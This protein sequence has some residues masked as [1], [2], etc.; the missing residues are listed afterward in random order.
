MLPNTLSMD[1]VYKKSLQYLL[2]VVGCLKNGLEKCKNIAKFSPKKRNF[3]N[4]S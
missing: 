3:S 2:W 1:V 4:F